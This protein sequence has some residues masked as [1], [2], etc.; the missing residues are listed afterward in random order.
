M[1]IPM[2][3]RQKLFRIFVVLA[4]GPFF[5]AA[6]SGV[7]M[8]D[9][10]ARLAQDKVVLGDPVTLELHLDGQTAA[11]SPDL[12][13][14]EQSFDILGTSQSMQTSIVNGVSSQSRSWLIQIAPREIGLL[15]VPE[16]TVGAETSQPLPLEVVDP[17][18]MPRGDLASTGV[19]IDVEVGSDTFYV[20]QE[21]PVTVR[22]MDGLGLRQARLT[23]LAV[24]NAT[25]RQVG[26]DRVSSTSF[27][28]RPVRVVER[29]YLVTPQASGELR[30]PALTL[31][32]VVTDPNARRGSGLGRDPF[33]DM[34]DRFGFPDIGGFGGSIFDDLMTP[35][36]EMT[37]RSEAIALDIAARPGGAD[38]WFLPAKS[39][40][41]R[42]TWQPDPPQLAVGQAATR[43]IQI[44]ALGTAQEQLPELEFDSIPGARIYVDRSDTR[45]AQTPEGSAAIRQYSLS[46]V[47]TESGKI[48]LPEV[49][50]NWFDVNAGEQRTASLAAETLEVAVG[51]SQA[52][53]PSAPQP[54]P[55]VS[56]PD[57][58]ETTDPAADFNLR[59]W[60]LAWR[61]E[62]LWGLFAIGLLAV[63]GTGFLLW[64]RKSREK[65]DRGAGA[66]PSIGTSRDEK[67]KPVRPDH[68]ELVAELREACK[69]GD[70]AKAYDRLL[71]W[72]NASG[73]EMARLPEDADA[74]LAAATKQL[75]AH[76]FGSQDTTSA[77]TGE[78][79][80]TAVKKV[81]KR[82]GTAA[83]GKPRTGNL[84]PLYSRSPA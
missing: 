71:A 12:A 38:E 29:T 52:T 58:P 6:L 22:I 46:I 78:V 53:A 77:W 72:R 17:A 15:T 27:Q 36:L 70:A 79:L 67:A 41:L 8:A 57:R 33:A 60:L 47:P 40:E 65:A 51:Q 30:I 43:I 18:T 76:V 59:D 10:N 35:T 5:A 44:T 28:G 4:A 82:R 50:V 45:E 75:E 7:A 13:P 64:R 73:A 34:R 54:D 61:Y 11:A 25:V 16:I 68:A 69:R 74:A 49:T 63:V 81:E 26:E 62:L 48:I 31:R 66:S 42:S 39:V 21:I 20:Q 9:V 32:G 3:A 24:E 2:R 84:P 56:A 19:Q 83:K 1:N 37:A 80:W 23:P 55:Q 14:L